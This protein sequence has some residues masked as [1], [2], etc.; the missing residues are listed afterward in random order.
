MRNFKLD[1]PFFESNPEVTFMDSA[2]SSLTPLSVIQAI[3]KYYKD[4]SIN[5][6]RGVY[7]LSVQATDIYEDTREQVK[8]FIHANTSVEIIYTKGTTEGFNL[9]SYILPHANKLNHIPH[10]FAWKNPL[11]SKDVIILSES[12]HHSNIVPWQIMAE[13]H[14]LEI[15]Y[16]P[17]SP[18]DGILCLDAFEKIKHSLQNREVKIVSL[19]LVSNVTGIIHD[20]E[21]FRNYA[22]EKGALFIIDAAQAICHLEID[23]QILDPDFLLFSAHKMLGPTG[24]GILYGKESILNHLP[25]FMGGGDMILDVAKEKTLYNQIPYK[26]EA[27]TPNIAG[28]FGLSAAITYMEAVSLS[29]IQEIDNTLLLYALK[30]LSLPQIIHYGP[31]LEDVQ[32]KRIKKT[33]ILSFSIKDIHP[34]DAG[35]FL[36]QEGIAIRVGHHCCQILMDAFK[37]PALCR[38]SL[39]FYNTNQDI[40]KLSDA[41][42]KMLTF[43]KVK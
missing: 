41:L 7:Q 2:A 38:A 11:A 6:H 5:I 15:Q 13:R 31:S 40:D 33:S 10:L 36:D 8:N 3:E 30:K 4:F 12:E 23:V 20:L 32:N 27:G 39:Y 24:I 9:L 17:V 29:T 26:Y 25:V 37:V 35:T 34:H 22:R 21:P 1:F 16:I 18:I 42:Y 14:N 19:S 28:V 43:F